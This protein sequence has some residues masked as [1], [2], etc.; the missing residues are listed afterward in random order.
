MKLR[1]LLALCGLCVYALSLMAVEVPYGKGSLDIL[2]LSPDAVRVRYTEEQTK[3]LP[4]WVYIPSTSVRSKLRHLGPGHYLFTTDA[5]RLE[6]TDGQ[7]M[8]VSDGQGHVI[9]CVEHLSLVPATVAGQ[10]TH[11]ATLSLVS[12]SDEHLYG[13]GQFQDGYVDVRGL[14]RRLTQVNTQIAIPMV[15]SNKGYGLLWN[16]YGLTDFNPADHQVA[17]QPKGSL[18]EA[19]RVNVTSTE[20]GRE[21]LRRKNVFEGELRIDESGQY[22][23]ML[24]VG[25]KMAR[26]HH[27][28]VDGRPVIDSRNLWLPPT[29]SVL[30]YLT[31]G[32]HQL[33]SELSDGDRP[34]IYYRITD[35]HDASGHTMGTT[36]FR[37]SVAQ[38]VDFT[39]FV[40]TPDNIVA[41]CHR[42][43][44]RAPMMPKWVLGYIHCRERFHSQQELLQVAH[45]FVERRHP[46]D[47]MVQDWQYWGRYGWNAMRFDEAQYPDPAAMVDSLHGMGMRFMVS[48]WSKVD[49]S[50]EVGRE[51]TDKGYYIPGTEWIDFFNADAVS[52][53]WNNLSRRMVVPFGLDALWQ[54]ATEPENDDLVGRRVMNGRY[55]GEW[56]RNVYP[57]LVNRTIYDGLRS[58][59]PDKRHLILTRSGFPG[60]QRY[61]ALMWSGDVGH[62]WATL[63]RQ[64]AGGLGMAA[65]GMPWWTYD[66]GGFFRPSDQYTNAEYIACM[67][68]WIQTSVFLPVMRVHGYMS[69][70]EPWRYGEKAERQFGESLRQR[71]R[72]LPYIYSLSALLSA[73]GRMLMR[74]MVFDFAADSV[75][76]RHS[77]RQYMFGPSLLVSPITAPDVSHWP[78]YLPACRGGWYDL[79]TS[80]HFEGGQTVQVAASAD[81]VPVLVKAGSILPLATDIAPTMHQNNSTLELRVFPGA[82]GQFTLYDDD[83]VSYDCE[84]GGSVT[85][86]LR[87][88]DRRRRLH[89]GACKGSYRDN[90]VVRRFNIM[91]EGKPY[92]VDYHGKSV[93]LSL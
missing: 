53:Y 54:D 16:N 5:M 1:R 44:G 62:D 11:E 28:M 29:A 74:P 51:M 61:G 64:I 68:R 21:E 78:V 39:L 88:D 18:G 42:A 6:V 43:T 34:T 36:V 31:A 15:I 3:A 45:T 58:A 41:A 76:L 25:Q 26:R 93:V 12:P 85:I 79:F 13:L 48:V 9:T 4:D 67:M 32:T 91:V 33:R 57:L 19:E 46:V 56:F 81:H 52:S 23:L 47:V 8:S 17:L 50:S 87:W 60:I 55:P 69:D 83:G 27:L 63:R 22:A 90:S 82:D 84:R 2:F 10:P 73:Q 77:D 37:S 65:A 7:G 92:H 30:V 86:A 35:P 89:I 71:Y 40:G 72:L 38:A 20:G 14:T 70:T 75:A 59:V 24:D 66:A 80:E 49:P